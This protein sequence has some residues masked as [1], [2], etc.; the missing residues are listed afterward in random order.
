MNKQNISSVLVLILSIFFFVSCDNEP[1]DPVLASQ[2]SNPT[3]GGGTGG[4]GGGSGSGGT[5]STGLFAADFGGQTWVATSTQANIYNGK[6]EIVGSK[7]AQNEGF[8]FSLNG[9]TAGSYSSSTNLLA[10]SP[11]NATDAYLGL[12]PND[13][14]EI[15]GSVIVTNID[16]VNHTIS[17]TFS[18]K[19]YW[20]DYTVTNVAPINFTNG[21]FTNI[22]YTSVNP[23]TDTFY[24]KSDGVEFVEDDIDV[25]ATIS[26]GFP[27]SYSIVGSKTNGDNIGLSIAQSLP[28]GTYQFTGP[29][30]SQINSSCL[31]GGVLYN[32]ESGSITITSKTATNMT[33]TFTIVVKNFTTNQTKTITDGAFS[34][35]L[36]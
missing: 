36:P 19:G 16:T 26:S 21:V 5:G 22:P 20:T 30:G 25:A 33:G 27:D 11:A 13:P 28:V 2:L 24:A 35:E 10:Y 8:G 18:F 7:G 29:F 6:I 4:T 1:L 14:A 34:V 15:A 3:N 32:G 17:G 12:N 31:F 23:V 9:M